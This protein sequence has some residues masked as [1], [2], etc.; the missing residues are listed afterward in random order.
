MEFGCCVGHKGG[1]WLVRSLVGLPVGE[2][3]T[4]QDSSWICTVIRCMDSWSLC[5]LCSLQQI[6]TMLEQFIN[7]GLSLFLYDEN[8][9]PVASVPI[10]LTSV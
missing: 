9:I 10:S 5:T 4:F 6:L 8:T 3:L 1:H 2:C 7:Y